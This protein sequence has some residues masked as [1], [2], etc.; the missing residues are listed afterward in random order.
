MSYIK[1]D[2]IHYNV[3]FQ[4]IKCFFYTLCSIDC[5]DQQLFFRDHL[6]VWWVTVLLWGR[7]TFKD[8]SY[9]FDFCIVSL[10]CSTSHINSFNFEIKLGWYLFGTILVAFLKRKI[11]WG[12]FYNSQQN[13]EMSCTH[14]HQCSLRLNNYVLLISFSKWIHY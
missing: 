13:I 12:I 6:T 1:K 4:E 8:T 11:H 3:S 7:L 14:T 10:L 2:P 5:F 9:F